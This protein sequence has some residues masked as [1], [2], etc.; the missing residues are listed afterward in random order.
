MNLKSKAEEFLEHILKRPAMFFGEGQDYLQCLKAFLFGYEVGYRDVSGSI[1]ED[2]SILP[3]GLHSFII[4]RLGED[5][6]RPAWSS[7]VVDTTETPEEAWDL[8]KQLYTEFKQNGQQGS[9]GKPDTV[10]S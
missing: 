8:F 5:K 9:D 7:R 6:A 4:S 3:E 10:A 2:H 1:E